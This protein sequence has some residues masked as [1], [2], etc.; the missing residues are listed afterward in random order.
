MHSGLLTLA[1]AVAVTGL[2]SVAFAEPTPNECEEAAAFFAE[3]LSPKSEINGDG[4]GWVLLPPAVDFYSLGPTD[5]WRELAR[6]FVSFKLYPV[7]L[8]QGKEW[9]DG[10]NPEFRSSWAKSFLMDDTLEQCLRPLALAAH[11][12]LQSE[13]EEFD[14][15]L[16]PD[17][18]AIL[19]PLMKASQ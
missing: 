2:V 19:R 5:Q 17:A 4:I 9:Y 16:S 1:P 11:P 13:V 12:E 6:R 15:E 18:R 10:I 3:V 14:A 8:E 7:K